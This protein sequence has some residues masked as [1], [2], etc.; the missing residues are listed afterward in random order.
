MAT[1]P[2]PFMFTAAWCNASA[3][4]SGPQLSRL[5]V[6]V[7]GAATCRNAKSC[8]LV[9]NAHG[10][11]EWVGWVGGAERFMPSPYYSYPFL[12]T[13]CLSWIGFCQT[14]AFDRSHPQVSVVLEL[15]PSQGFARHVIEQPHTT[16][17][18]SSPAWRIDHSWPT[19][20]D[21]EGFCHRH[22]QPPARHPSCPVLLSTW[23]SAQEH[24]PLPRGH[25]L[26]DRHGMTQGTTTHCCAVCFVRP[27]L[28]IMSCGAQVTVAWCWVP[29]LHLQRLWLRTG[30]D[31]RLLQWSRDS[32]SRL[33]L[34]EFMS[35]RSY[36]IA[37]RSTK[38]AD[39][40]LPH[41]IEFLTFLCGSGSLQP[42][43]P[44]C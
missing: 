19:H 24:V 20:C 18:R 34:S 4:L 25:R 29:M 2:L 22:V 28:L 27:V 43:Q 41:L 1:L 5:G 38:C 9:V 12:K 36:L 14:A 39:H 44:K 13:G 21:L 15:G 37:N 11:K 40:H 31:W 33:L 26:P 7:L 35:T 10:S 3:S 30:L 17:K 16:A 32:G 8:Q 23:P 42:V 6:E